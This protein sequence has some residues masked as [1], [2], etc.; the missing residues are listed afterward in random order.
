MPDPI[1]K[2]TT[3]ETKSIEDMSKTM[4]S[5]KRAA[6]DITE[7]FQEQLA[8][9]TQLKD[10]MSQL[11]ENMEKLDK[12]GM[13]SLSSDNIK[14]VADKTK[15]LA[16]ETKNTTSS[17]KKLGDAMQTKFA[18]A[19]LVAVAALDGF[20]QGLKNIAAHAKLAVDGITWLGGAMFD[21]GKAILSIPLRMI[22][23]LFDMATQ[24]GGDTS[25]MQALEDVR[26]EFGSLRSE[27]SKTVI[28]VSK[29]MGKLNS[30]GVSAWRIWGNMAERMQAVL[31]FAQGMGPAFQVFQGEFN[32]NGEAI[33]RYAKG[34][35]ITEEQMSSIS[36]NALR[37]GKSIAKVQNE[38]TK[39]ALGMSKAFGVNAKVISKDM[40]KAMQ[41]LA[42]FGHLSTKE[43]AITATFANKLGVSVDKLTAVMDAT[44]TYDSTVD[45]M[46]KLNEQFGLNIDYTE[47]M[48]AENPADQLEMLRKEFSRAG[49]DVT[50]FNRFQRDLVKNSTGMSDEMINAAFSTKNAGVS[51]EKM[52][53][54][55]DKAEKKTMTQAEAMSKLA[56]S[57]ERI[58]PSGGG[59]SS[60]LFERI[61]EGFK[62]GVQSAPEFIQLMRNIQ[63]ILM[64][65]QF[66]GYKLG[67][68]F[69]DL[70][71]GVRD[72]FG[73]L[74]DIFD[75]K[76]FTA[77]TDKI[78]A[79]F[80]VFKTGGVDAFG[81]FMNNIK[82]IFFDFFDKEKGPGRKVLVGFKKFGETVVKLVVQAAKWAFKELKNVY[83]LFLNE[84]SNPSD[85][86]QA[87][88]KFITDMSKTAS[89][90]ITEKFVP[91]ATQILNSI[92][93]FLDD[94]SKLG[95][96]LPNKSAF[97]KFLSDVFS[98]LWKAIIDMVKNP[99]LQ[100]AV[101]DFLRSSGMFLLDSIQTV[102]SAL[103]WYAKIGVIA[104]YFGPA[105]TKTLAMMGSELILKPGLSFLGNLIL[106]QLSG[107][108]AKSVT[109]AAASSAVTDAATKGGATFVSKFGP[110]FA[111]GMRSVSG[112]LVKLAKSLAPL[113][114]NPITLIILSAIALAAGSIYLIRDFIEKESSKLKRKM[115]EKEY[116]EQQNSNVSIDEKLKAA[117]E[118][119]LKLLE[120][121]EKEEGHGVANWLRNSKS[122]RQSN[123]EAAA[124]SRQADIDRLMKEKEKQ[125]RAFIKG[126][127][128]Y[129]A[130]MA[131]EAKKRQLDTLGPLTIENAAER[132]KKVDE[133]AKKVMSK[134]FDI[135]PKLEEIRKKFDTIDFTLMIPEK[136]DQFNKAIIAIDGLRS[137]IGGVLDV[138][139]MISNF[140][141]S[142][143]NIKVDTLKSGFDTINE[144]TK[145]VLESLISPGKQ[146]TYK[147]YDEMSTI[148]T[149]NAGKLKTMF[150]EVNS[151]FDN[152]LSLTSSISKIPAAAPSTEQF[153]E[154][155]STILYI[156]N[157][158]S[159]VSIDASM[160]NEFKTSMS[161]V[162]SGFNK[163]KET[164]DS[165]MSFA[166][167]V[168]NDSLKN[169]LLAVGDMIAQTQKIDDVLSTL[170]PMNFGAKLS[171]VADGMGLGGKFAYTVKSKE[172]V[173]KIDMTVSMDAAEVESAIVHRSESII[174]DRLNFVMGSGNGEN[175]K[176]DESITST[177]PT[178]ANTASTVT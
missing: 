152:L 8:V 19:A 175:K 86:T 167:S 177:G 142:V 136:E 37:M 74:R 13:R 89:K 16:G 156:S 102:W 33:M 3:I 173:I 150:G 55:G 56:D 114:S 11:G 171:K 18:K 110:A 113:L 178:L 46:S 121:A 78:V 154:T 76:T 4:Q 20:K 129:N 73:G 6:E 128:E 30:S 7:S 95:A 43:M 68:M 38:M 125:D 49:V 91:L 90:F 50:K 25:L 137:M 160:I 165:M 92:T 80:N 21:M 36:S 98:P 100:K 22:Q 115:D 140:S 134:D 135:G 159:G 153:E 45:S 94:P 168:T 48:A 39:Q 52:R 32:E 23:G 162:D 155:L 53:K 101:K 31:K 112:T 83:A 172:V 119:R 126:T 118:S 1:D 51:L 130:R 72:V 41:D 97:G 158:F 70:F 66:F 47:M 62:R 15:N 42:H 81:D 77:V 34:L 35:G 75:P 143:K 105:I 151:V 131:E 169:A 12:T 157:I 145:A 117:Q 9:M 123:L 71:P 139:A 60:S 84:L 166:Q 61:A 2:K 174:R 27:S 88:F 82:K 164:R 40:A 104:Y 161:H 170:P 99:K 106:N 133:I 26:K 87:I 14:K 107:T 64:K 176:V 116:R 141:S 17:F 24:G 44:K 29:G 57:I 54:E 148:V 10:V 28:D 127:E 108:L 79:A 96:A 120:E 5:V 138:G 69:R 144:V 67:K 147:T 149:Q 122:E 132:F 103:P 111:S 93:S 109:N 63:L 59:G 65:A 85:T 58:V 124:D 146:A 163:L